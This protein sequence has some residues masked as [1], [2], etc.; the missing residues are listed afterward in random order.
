LRQTIP[1]ASMYWASLATSVRSRA[2]NCFNSVVSTTL[3]DPYLLRE[4]NS[5]VSALVSSSLLRCPP[6]HT[7]IYFDQATFLQIR[8]EFALP[9][10]AGSPA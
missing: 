10:S 6:D 2:E 5:E 8:G 7:E 4:D 9:E 1:Q 3:K